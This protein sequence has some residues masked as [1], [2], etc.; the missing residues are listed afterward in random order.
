MTGLSAFTSVM[1]FSTTYEFKFLTRSPGFVK[2]IEGEGMPLSKTPDVRGDL[3][4]HFKI[5]FPEYINEKQKQILR[6]TL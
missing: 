3:F 4:I 2:K 1:S 5:K 6:Q